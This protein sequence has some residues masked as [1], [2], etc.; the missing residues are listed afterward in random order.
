MINTE[1]LVERYRKTDKQGDFY[2]HLVLGLIALPLVIAEAVGDLADF[3][4][5][6]FNRGKPSK[7][8]DSDGWAYMDSSASFGR[9]E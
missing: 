5:H 8:D 3:T 4:M 2:S 9:P 1:Q 7:L 6:A